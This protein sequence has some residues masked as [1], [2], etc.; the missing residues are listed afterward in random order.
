VSE[1]EVRITSETGGEKGSKPQQIHQIPPMFLLGLSEVYAHA[2][3]T[4]YKDI[5]PGVP[6]WAVG[7][8]W[9]L[10]YSAMMRHLNKFWMG[11]YY[12]E[13]D[14]LPHLLHA[15]WHCATLY[16][17]VEEGIE[18]GFDDRPKY[19]K[20]PERTLRRGVG[21]HGCQVDGPTELR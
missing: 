14:G 11:E 17:W 16:T 12:D 19:Y 10:S 5:S 8:P 1:D 9:S 4:K 21:S 15:A 6:N 13:D 7:Y 2:Q 20:D 18:P 3:E